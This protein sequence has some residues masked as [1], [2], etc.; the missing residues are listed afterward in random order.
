MERESERGREEGGEK[1]EGGSERGRTREERLA[2][3]LSVCYIITD[4]SGNGSRVLSSFLI[5]Q[6]ELILTK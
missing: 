2:H 4:Y 1:G 5:T 3:L 6:L